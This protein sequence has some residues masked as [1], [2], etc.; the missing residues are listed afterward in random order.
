MS[1]RV[2]TIIKSPFPNVSDRAEI[3]VA[4]ADHLYREI[5]IENSLTNEN[6]E[7]VSL[8]L[9]AQV[10]VTVEAKAES[11][12]KGAGRR[13]HRGQGRGLSTNCP[14]VQYSASTLA[15][16]FGAL[17]SAKSCLI[18]SYI[19]DESEK[20]FYFDGSTNTAVP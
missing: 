1:G 11:T 17:A 7:K 2:E 14:D 4:G 16:P 13:S 6:G 19:A 9:G 5:R 15:L 12:N 18:F 20:S 3:H 10:E 8:K